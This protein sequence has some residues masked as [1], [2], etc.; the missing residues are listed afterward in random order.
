MVTA[1]VVKMV[2]TKTDV[3]IN[4]VNRLMDDPAYYASMTKTYALYEKEGACTQILKTL[5][6]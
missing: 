5:D 2:G 4:E 3:I 6:L 1:G